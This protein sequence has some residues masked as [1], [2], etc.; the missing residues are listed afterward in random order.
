MNETREASLSSVYPVCLS[1]LV[2]H[3]EFCQVYIPT[4]QVNRI[5][6]QKALADRMWPILSTRVLHSYPSGLIDD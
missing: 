2:V 4:G 6:F 1:F 5:M 3:R